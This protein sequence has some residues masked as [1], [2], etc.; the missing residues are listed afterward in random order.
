LGWDVESWFA[1]VLVKDNGRRVGI[2]AWRAELVGR[3]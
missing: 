3:M 2:E 1:R